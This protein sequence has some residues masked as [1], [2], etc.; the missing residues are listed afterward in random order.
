L[1]WNNYDDTKKCL[2]SLRLAT[3]PN[4]RVMVVDNGSVDNSGSQLASE[5][6]EWRF[7][8]N[9]KNLGFARGCNAGI[10]AALQDNLC[11]YVALLNNDA[12]VPPAFLEKAIDTAEANARIGVVGGKIL[13]SP[14]EKR[15][16]YAGGSIDRLRAGCRSRGGLRIDRGQF[17]KARTTGFITGALMLIKREVLETVGLLAEEYFFGVEDMDYSLKVRRAGYKLYYVP[18]F[19]AYHRGDGSHNTYDPKFSY[20]GYRSRFIFQQKYFPRILFS[21][22]QKLFII[23]EKQIAWRRVRKLTERNRGGGNN[24]ISFDDMGFALIK[25]IEDHDKICLS[26]EALVRFENLLKERN[27]RLAG[28]EQRNFKQTN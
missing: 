6:S 3:Y 22:W 23:Y 19:L 9:D 14:Q 11:A 25:A 20:N 10:R 13:T 17:D 7:I 5:F 15:I 18:E 27:H 1:N 28:K 4:L 2:D 12:T 24:E 21:L 26:E 8:F 16:C